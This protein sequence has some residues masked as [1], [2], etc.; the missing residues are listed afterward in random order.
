MTYS[1][2]YGK[3]LVSGGWLREGTGCWWYDFGVVFFFKKEIL[4]KTRGLV[5]GFALNFITN[6]F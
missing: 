1:S 5:Q 6:N 3:N 4:S 2:L